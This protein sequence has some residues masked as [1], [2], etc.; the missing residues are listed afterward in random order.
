VS[1]ARREPP[2][3][4]WYTLGEALE[5][6]AVLEDARDALIDAGHLSVVVAVEAQVRDLNRRLEFDDPWGGA[7]D[8]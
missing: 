6:L 7:D 2:R 5:L 1:P 3:H 8:R 4:I